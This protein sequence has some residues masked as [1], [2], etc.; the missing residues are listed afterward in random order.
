MAL[1]LI[2]AVEGVT[3]LDA[4]I[5]GYAYESNRSV[6]IVVNKWDAVPKGPD[7]VAEFTETVR[8]KMKYL[9]FAPLVFVSA[10]KGQRLGKLL[11]TIVDVS[12]ARRFRI[13]T[14]DMNR[15]L[16]K[17][18]FERAPSPGGKALRLYY[19]T[20]ASVSPPT[21]VAFINR[22]DAPHFSVERFL[23]NRIRERFPFWEHPL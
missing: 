12:A 18:D 1:L 2:D 8:R 13:P 14:A 19:L 3:D 20:Q 15:F 4:N 6:I 11:D 9:D 5:G 21:F 17:L 7:A 16:Q 23:K 22:A 10:L